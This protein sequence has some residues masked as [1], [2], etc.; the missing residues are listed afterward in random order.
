MENA[1]VEHRDGG[2]WIKG[3]RVSLDSI[4]YEFKDGAAPE[5]IRRS[6][7][8]LSLEQV[9]GAITFYL[10]KQSEID[11]YLAESEEVF[12]Q[13]RR[14]GNA[15]ARAERPELFSRIDKARQERKAIRK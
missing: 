10:S 2:Y 4:V 9:Y 12:E 8:T 5:S 7:S 3:S 13:Q 15:R 11:A 1:Y 14:E 6:F